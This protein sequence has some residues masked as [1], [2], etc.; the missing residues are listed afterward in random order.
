MASPAPVLPDGYSAIPGGTFT[1]DG[2]S[3]PRTVDPFGKKMTPV[4]NEEY[5]A[6]ATSL[7]EDRF[8]LLEHDWETGVT[9]LFRRGS[10]PEVAVQGPVEVPEY[11][12]FD[13]GDVIIF[14]SQILLKMVDNP[15]ALYDERG[16]VFSGDYQP[17]IG[18]S[19]FH[20][21]AWCLLKSVQDPKFNYRLPT[22]L[23][24]EAVA[25]NFGKCEYG[26]EACTSLYNES[27][28]KLAHVDED[29]YSDARS[30][31]PI[32]SLLYF[33]QDLPFDIQTTGNVWRW[34]QMNP[35]F[36]RKEYGKEYVLTGPYGVRGGSWSGQPDYAHA[37]F[38][39]PSHRPS[40]SD[41]DI[42][43]QPVVVRQD[44]K[45]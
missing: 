29:G 19:Y 45:K 33:N 39:D 26:T 35:A 17:A 14:G 30:T 28:I 13:Q 24:Y 5:G 1:P 22:D 44:S 7:G 2:A 6:V 32:Y 36:K 15:S 34:I 9:E 16:I 37:A 11:I 31:V 25:S 23:E 4:T 21:T 42:G 40:F 12:L 3:A 8:I 10:T 43:F 18:V 20:A 27:G 38:R 41:D